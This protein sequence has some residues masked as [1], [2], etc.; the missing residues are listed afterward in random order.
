MLL[1]NQQDLGLA[2]F[3]TVQIWHPNDGAYEH[4]AVGYSIMYGS[5]AGISA[6]GLTVHEANL[7]TVHIYFR[8]FLR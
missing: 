2:N 4:S 8:Y 3:K 1:P 7:E 6:K 5:L